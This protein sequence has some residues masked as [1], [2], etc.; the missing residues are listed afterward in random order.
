VVLR[1]DF[2][3]LA[4]PGLRPPGGQAGWPLPGGWAAGP[5]RFL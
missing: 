3:E 2:I 4:E 1:L 5:D